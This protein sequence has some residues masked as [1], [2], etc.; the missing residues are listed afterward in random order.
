M[1]M[2]GLAVP[3]FKCPQFSWL[4]PGIL[5]GLYWSWSPLMDLLSPKVKT[6]K[7]SEGLVK[8]ANLNRVGCHQANH[9]V[10]RDMEKHP[11][12]KHDAI[13]DRS[14]SDCLRRV[15]WRRGP[16]SCYLSRCHREKKSDR[17]PHPLSIYTAVAKPVAWMT[18]VRRA[19]VTL[20]EMIADWG[21]RL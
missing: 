6:R 8:Q 7:R 19:R 4:L 16:H 14:P 18:T 15:S 5:R 2:S 20:D 11:Q 12:P 17:A 9:T 1:V 21:S 10:G 13:K 3:K